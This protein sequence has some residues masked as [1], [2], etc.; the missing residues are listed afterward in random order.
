[1]PCRLEASCRSAE[2]RSGI[3]TLTGRCPWWTLPTLLRCDFLAVTPRLLTSS[4]APLYDEFGRVRN[5]DAESIF[6]LLNLVGVGE[7]DLED[8][9][10]MNLDKDLDVGE[11]TLKL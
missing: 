11:G 4:Q 3:P 2:P 9:A 1:M 7:W 8:N 6:E 10:V 5:G